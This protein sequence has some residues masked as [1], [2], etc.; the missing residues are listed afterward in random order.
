M[1]A[2]LLKLTIWLPVLVAHAGL[3]WG[4]GPTGGST[5]PVVTVQPPAPYAA[6]TNYKGPN[7]H[8]SAMIDPNY[9]NC[10]LDC[11][12]QRANE[13]ISLQAKYIIKKIEFLN[14]PPEFAS[15]EA[16]IQLLGSFY[17]AGEDLDDCIGR[18]M[19]MNQFWFVKA[20]SALGKNETSYTNLHCA[21]VS[22]DGKTCEIEAPGSPAILR[23]SKEA[24][25]GTCIEEIQEASGFDPRQNPKKPKMGQ[26]A[27]FSRY[28]QLKMQAPNP[29]QLASVQDGVMDKATINNYKPN[30]DDFIRFKKVYLNSTSSATVEVP[31][32]GANRYDEPA[33]QK[34]LAAWQAAEFVEDAMDT[35]AGR[36][37]LGKLRAEDKK[38]FKNDAVKN[39][40]VN[41]FIYNEARG[42]YIDQVNQFIKQTSAFNSTSSALSFKGK[43]KGAKGPGGK[44]VNRPAD[45]NSTINNIPLPERQHT[46]NEEVNAGARI[47]NYTTYTPNAFTNSILPPGGKAVERPADQEDFS[48]PFF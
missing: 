38:A 48:N 41:R 16:K 28:D 32:T 18:Y 36:K 9:E 11:H 25:D 31:E 14:R 29:A 1:R 43:R 47:N 4:D 44:G 3:A 42:E 19:R 33:Y 7:S 20:G 27:F 26:G 22:A 30:H 46:G 45:P 5:A 34:A 39:D 13:N 6:G 2:K 35:V 8:V 10:G 21:K 23:C 40:S 15:D 12:Y 17:V 24:P 37:D